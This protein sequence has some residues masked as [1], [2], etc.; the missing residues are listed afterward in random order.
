MRCVI[1]VERKQCKTHKCQSTQSCHDCRAC[2][3]ADAHGYHRALP[4]RRLVRVADEPDRLAREVSA[5][6]IR[7]FTGEN[8]FLSTLFRSRVVL[9]GQGVTEDDFIGYPTAEHALQVG[10]ASQGLIC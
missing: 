8:E 6:T 7:S 3:R 2:L 5:N 10:A 9:P 1:F 4:H